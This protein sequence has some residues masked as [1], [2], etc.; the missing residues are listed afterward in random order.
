MNRL[1]GSLFCF[2]T[3]ASSSFR[4][5]VGSRLHLSALSSIIVSS[6]AFYFLQETRPFHFASTLSPPASSTKGTFVLFLFILTMVVSSMYYS[7]EDWHLEVVWKRGSEKQKQNKM[8]FFLA[9]VR[10]VFLP[11][12]AWI[13]TEAFLPLPP[14]PLFFFFTS[15][16][17][18]QR[19]QELPVLVLCFSLSVGLLRVWCGAELVSAI[20]ERCTELHTR[21]VG[22]QRRLWGGCIQLGGGWRFAPASRL[23]TK[24][25]INTKFN[26]VFIILYTYIKHSFTPLC[27]RQHRFSSKKPIYL[28]C[29]QTSFSSRPCV[30][31]KCLVHECSVFLILFIVSVKLHTVILS[32]PN[33]LS[34]LS[35]DKSHNC[36]S[37]LLCILSQSEASES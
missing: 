14:R 34:L 36:F 16:D 7:D 28:S 30:G 19:Y 17:G 37:A 20:W 3:N 12:C 2:N 27:H 22:S 31:W 15:A 18:K 1:L 10:L 6:S 8:C 9:K 21:L 5:D 24:Y 33:Q 13:Q 29:P 26:A 35:S 32:V 4:R 11:L 23:K 25:G